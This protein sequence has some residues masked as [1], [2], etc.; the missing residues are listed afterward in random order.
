M[1]TVSLQAAQ[2]RFASPTDVHPRQSA[3]VRPLI[4]VNIQ[5]SGEHDPFATGAYLAK[6][7]ADKFLARPLAR[8]YRIMLYSSSSAFDS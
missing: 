7:S 6:P 4:H 2:T 5:L 8:V 3:K 1:S